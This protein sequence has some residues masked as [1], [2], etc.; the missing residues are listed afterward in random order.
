MFKCFFSSAIRCQ[1]QSYACPQGDT[2]CLYAPLS[3]SYNFITFP[4]NIRFPTDLFT[5]RGPKSHHRKLEFELELTSAADPITGESRVSRD[6]F[7]L[8]RTGEFE[9]LVR[10]VQEVDGPQD[11]EL[12]LKMHIYSREFNENEPIFFGT[13]LAVIKIYVTETF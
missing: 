7:R 1:R 11:V 6:F 10:L 9:T 5:M 2:E 3:V 12:R 4:S 8:Q 13:A